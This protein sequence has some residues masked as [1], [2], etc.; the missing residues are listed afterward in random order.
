MK[1][2][3]ISS[4]TEDSILKQIKAL[5][6]RGFFLHTAGFK[7]NAPRTHHKTREKRRREKKR[8]DRANP[9]KLL[10]SRA[11]WIRDKTTFKGRY[12]QWR[13]SL[14]SQH[15]QWY[16]EILSFDEWRLLWKKAGNI[17]LGDGSTKPAWRMRG[18]NGMLEKEP[19]RPQIRRWDTKKPYVLS[20]LYVVVGTKVL[21][22]G[23]LLAEQ[24][25]NE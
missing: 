20:N 21:A 2:Q 7:S 13:S 23:E 14:R 19:I 9:E 24:I 25:L 5:E 4:I 3:T 10:K 11:K 17:T 1:I 22:D 8:E 6:G 16:N 15:P 18:G 12:N